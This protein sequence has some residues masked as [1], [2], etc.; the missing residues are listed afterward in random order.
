MQKC[1]DNNVP[2][3]KGVEK[4]AKLY[5]RGCS[6]L[7]KIM[8]V[9]F[10]NH[11]HWIVFIL[12]DI[13]TLHLNSMYAIHRQ[14]VIKCFVRGIRLCWAWCKGYTKISTCFVDFMGKQIVTPFV[15]QQVKG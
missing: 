5:F 10:A 9:P 4:W 8:V 15:S 1:S 12:D 3:Y 6:N 14:D 11:G 7:T 2:S 13:M